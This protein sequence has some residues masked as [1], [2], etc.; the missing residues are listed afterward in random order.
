M[1]RNQSGCVARSLA[2]RA[3][4]WAGCLRRIRR[5]RVPPRWA[6]CDWY[7]EI[8]AE[9][10]AAALQAARDF[11]P[12]RGTP[13]D[14]FVRARIMAG[15]L[16]RYRREWTLAIRQVGAAGMEGFP[17]RPGDSPLSEAA[18]GVLQEALGQ[19]S[20]RDRGLI[21]RLFWG[22]ATETGIAA[23]LGVSQQAVSKHKLA[24]LRALRQTI[25]RM[26]SGADWL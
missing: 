23:G 17:A 18:Y 2:V 13:W 22:G 21:E 19:L 3:A 24:I 25:V 16:A 15:A 12:D 20:P 1:V 5:W 10:A 14:A 11:D 9:A 4:T 6:A 8:R 26:K 7:E